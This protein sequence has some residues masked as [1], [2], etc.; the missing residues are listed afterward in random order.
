MN[1]PGAEARGRLPFF[2]VSG[3]F[4]N[5]MNLRHLAGLVGEDRP[6]HGIQA[7]GLFGGEEPH[8]TF[9]EMA[10]DYL[11]EIRAVQ[12]TGPYL[13]GGFSGGGIAAYE[14]ARQLIEAGE[15]VPLLVLLDTPLPSDDPLT[16]R[17]RMLIH[18]QNLERQG[19]R[20]VLNW[21]EK[22]VAYRQELREREQARVAQATQA[23]P[24]NFRSQ[25]IE[26]AFYRALERYAIQPL[27]T[28]V[29]LFRPKLRPTHVF[30][31]GKA[32]NKDRRRIYHDNGWSRYITQVEVF[33][34]PGNHDSMVLEPN[35]RILA[36]HLRPALD[37]AERIGKTPPVTTRGTNGVTPGMN[38]HGRHAD[39]NEPRG[40][41]RLDAEG[42]A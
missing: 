5:V 39:A 9:E 29:L 18:K 34:T 41:E 35:V 31:P 16:R 24:V 22:K 23:D 32:I 33:E 4:G 20:F 37:H 12:P 21:L 17:E 30:G 11:A 25:L 15:S 3:M 2:L 13:L 38:G 6:F 28:P 36:A 8:E 10:R 27:P 7:R 1:P 26:A 40:L 19:P 42:G 14:I